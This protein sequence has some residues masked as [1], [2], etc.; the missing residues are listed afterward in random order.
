[1]T[2]EIQTNWVRHQGNNIATKFPYTFRIPEFSM[3]KVSLQDAASGVIIRDLDPGEY[4]IT[5]VSQDNYDGGEVTYPLSGPPLSE[6]FYLLLQRIAP[7]KQELD[8]E[9]QG[10]FYPE[11]VEYQLDK[12][13]FQIQQLKAATDGAIIVPPGETPPEVVEVEGW[14]NQAKE[15]A[16]NAE[17]ARDFAYEW[18]S[19][20]EDQPV[21]DGEN[22]QGFSSFS[23]SKKAE[24]SAVA[25]A[26]SALAASGSAGAAA[27]SA[28][29]A[30][31]AKGDAEAAR[32]AASGSAISAS[33]SA[34]IA[35]SAA[36]D[37]EDARD[38]ASGYAGA[39]SNSAGLAA[40]DRI[41]TGL[42]RTQTGLDAAAAQAS[43]TKADKWANNPE[44]VPVEPG[45]FSAYHWSKKAEAAAGGGVT[46]VGLSAPT[47]FTVSGSPV[48]GSG[49]LT[50]AYASGYT[51]FTTTL[52]NKLDGIETGAQVNLPVG[53]GAGTVADGVASLQYKGAIG[54]SEDLDTYTTPGIYVQNSNADAGGGTNYPAPYA[55][56]LEVLDGGGATNVQT[57]QR[58][59]E[60]SQPPIVWQRMRRNGGN[61]SAWLNLSEW[62]AETVSQVE[63][64]AGTSTDANVKWSPER[65]AQAIAALGSN[66]GGAFTNV[67]ASRAKNTVYQNTSGRWRL[68]WLANTNNGIWPQISQNTTFPGSPNPGVQSG[69]QHFGSQFLVPPGW[70]YRA[71]LSGTSW[72]WWEN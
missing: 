8:I 20:P 59:T 1:M 32:D 18:A 13:E 58:Y 28:N 5:G 64:E 70:Y 44:D 56:M 67:T 60:Y 49:T 66:I 7:F 57:V 17:V 43:E 55:G 50:F 40:A 45:K 9:N 30:A 16:S 65:V 72:Q 48:T 10:G 38:L 62:M 27:G 39:A 46:S 11:S 2:V 63:A 6:N 41:Q 37:A 24:A 19:A 15:A 26:G 53:I 42:D 22:P 35:T 12:L 29:A 47:G 69:G 71:D 21:D 51:G 23:H 61:W 36:E 33:T 68:V 54:A 25:A 3:V 4:T 52:K 14:A 31:I 34:G